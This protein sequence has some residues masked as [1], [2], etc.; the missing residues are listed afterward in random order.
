MTDGTA[1]M[2]PVVLE[3][4]RTAVSGTAPAARPAAVPRRCGAL[5]AVWAEGAPP[6]I[7][8]CPSA[9]ARA[10]TAR[11]GRRRAFGRSAGDPESS[12]SVRVDQ[13][14]L[15]SDRLRRPGMLQSDIQRQVILAQQ[16]ILALAVTHP[17]HDL[18]T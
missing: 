17:T 13:L 8:R 6:A 12:S 1:G 4:A 10:G 5:P 2:A 3:A 15:T 11:P 14:R 7:G 9:R 18:I 16:L